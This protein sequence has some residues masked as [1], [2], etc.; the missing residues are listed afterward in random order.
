SRNR[1]RWFDI[2]V[3]VL[4]YPS[5][6]SLQNPQG[7]ARETR[8]VAA[9]ADA[10]ACGLDANQPDVSVVDECIEDTHGVAAA[11]D[12]RNH[13]G[14]KTPALR[15]HLRTRLSADDGLELADHE[16]IRMRPQ[17]AAKKI[18]RVGHVRDP[19]AHGLVDR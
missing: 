15:E 3:R 19:V 1:V 16:W 2:A 6:G 9:R 14:R 10:L 17:D 13:R 7:A 5:L 8:S 4:Q 12:R 18:V 11:A